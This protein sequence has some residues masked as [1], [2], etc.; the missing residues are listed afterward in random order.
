MGCE[1]K[2][3]GQEK[4]GGDGGER[5]SEIAIERGSK[6]ER[7]RETDFDYNNF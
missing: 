3:S 4:R 6:R 5:G 1:A 2:P 7:E